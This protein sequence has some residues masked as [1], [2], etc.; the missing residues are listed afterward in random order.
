MIIV[1]FYGLPGCGKSTI[2]KG[3]YEKLKKL[4]I[5]VNLFNKNEYLEENKI[6]K[7]YFKDY[8]RL[9]LPHNLN[10]MFE[11]IFNMKKYK[12]NQKILK[13]D[14]K[15]RIWKEL[16]LVILYDKLAY[17]KSDSV[18][19]VDQGII[20]D[21]SDYLMF[22]DIT[23]EIIEK[24]LKKYTQSKNKFIFV[25]CE[26]SVNES[27]NR[28]KSRN[29]KIYAFDYLEDDE[30]NEFL[31]EQQKILKNIDKE[32]TD[33]ENLNKIKVIPKTEFL[34]KNIENLVNE[35]IRRR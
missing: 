33:K 34:E 27:I 11:I 29:R 18:I 17:T 15:E 7:N 12:K 20:Q 14:L 22:R 9:L 2:T 30:L 28:I 31:T 5:D 6:K 24:Y 19:L 35:V 10:F 8:I 4:E 13:Q 32:I 3:V 26:I 23:S 25:N 21:F 16:R 1:D